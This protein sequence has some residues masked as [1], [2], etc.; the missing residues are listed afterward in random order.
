[1]VLTAAEQYVGELSANQCL[2]WVHNSSECYPTIASIVTGCTFQVGV[3]VKNNIDDKLHET[4][5]CPESSD[6]FI[7]SYGGGFESV[8]IG[9]LL[10][11]KGM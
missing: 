2:L 4:S 9:C 8:I 11:A 1:M 3:G 10:L 7:S 6:K 5:A